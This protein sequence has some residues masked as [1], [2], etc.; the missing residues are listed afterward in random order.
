MYKNGIGRENEIQL[1]Q[2]K[3]YDSKGRQK[4]GRRYFSTSKNKEHKEPRNA[5]TQESQ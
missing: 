5:N 4:T 2:N 3:V 1:K